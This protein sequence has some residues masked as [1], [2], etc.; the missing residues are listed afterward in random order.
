MDPATVRCLVIG[1]I[2]DQFAPIGSPARQ[3][4]EDAAEILGTVIEPACQQFGITPIRSDQMRHPGDIPTQVYT[5]L[6]DWELVIADLTDANPNVMY[7]LAFRHLTGRCVI[8]LSEVGRIPWNIGHLRTQLFARNT[9]GLIDVRKRLE[10]A[11]TVVI[12]DG[13]VDLPVRQVFLGAVTAPPVTDA[14]PPLPHLA[15]A[16]PTEPVSPPQSA[17]QFEADSG[18][19]SDELGFL[20]IL[21]DWQDALGHAA[22]TMELIAQVMGDMN[23]IT[24]R[25]TQEIAES[26]AKTGGSPRDRLIIASRFAENLSH[27]ADRLEPL[28]ASY[29]ADITRMDRGN[30]YLLE[31]I[32]AAPDAL[33]SSDTIQYLASL[34][35]LRNTTAQSMA[36]S[37]SLA[38][39]TVGF[40]RAANVLRGPS[41][42]LAS[43]LRRISTLARPIYDWAG[44]AEAIIAAQPEIA[45]AHPELALLPPPSP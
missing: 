15:M 27:I 24:E 12:R 26:D 25:S 41:A 31:Q 3:I 4:Y 28:V 44:R 16:V 30:S 40:A 10:A 21:A 23:A 42:R 11:I 29:E 34:L 1:P 43:T 9:A 36:S 39:T 20:D 5:A 38:A 8:A 35:L 14:I 2:G 13:C 7:E 33:Q 45:S 32:Q 6:R 17:G 37:D 19:F 18:R 22:E